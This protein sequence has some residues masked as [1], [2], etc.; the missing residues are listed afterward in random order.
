MSWVIFIKTKPIIKPINTSCR[1][2]QNQDLKAILAIENL[3]YD[4]P[5]SQEKITNS[6]DNT[7]ALANVV[8]VDDQV[9]GYLLALTCV[10][11]VD[12][13]NICIHPKHQH[14]GLGRQLFNHF[15]HAI[16]NTATK[17]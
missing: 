1:T 16:N 3:A 8:L 4:F 12:I 13:L 7:N 11:F 6:T 14:Q 5:W 2:Y 15:K 17:S 10:D 9:V